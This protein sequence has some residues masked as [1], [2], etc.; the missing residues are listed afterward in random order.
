MCVA[1]DALSEEATKDAKNTNNLFLDTMPLS[2]EGDT[3]V[4]QACADNGGAYAAELLPVFSS[5]PQVRSDKRTPKAKQQWQTF[6]PAVAVDEFAKEYANLF[7]GRMKRPTTPRRQ[8]RRCA[9]QALFKA[10][11]GESARETLLQSCDRWMKDNGVRESLT[12]MLSIVISKALA[13]DK[14]HVSLDDHW[15]AATHMLGPLEQQGLNCASGKLELGYP[16]A[17]DCGIVWIIA[18]CTRQKSMLLLRAFSTFVFPVMITCTRRQLNM[19][20]FLCNAHKKIPWTAI[21]IWRCFPYTRKRPLADVKG[22]H[23]DNAN[24]KVVAAAG[25][26]GTVEDASVLA[27][28]ARSA[29]KR[30]LAI[31]LKRPSKRTETG[32]HNVVS[33]MRERK[34]IKASCKQQNKTTYNNKEHDARVRGGFARIGSVLVVCPAIC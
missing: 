12:S 15:C 22:L 16:C 33:R 23:S 14:Q 28:V 7:Q 4:D 2:S 32:H 6:L 24:L 21:L 8:S 20:P 29:A 19:Q 34:E 25:A 17:C 9:P 27:P 30:F 13:E 3:H 18:N 1:S 26:A 5:M 11:E 10:A 31:K